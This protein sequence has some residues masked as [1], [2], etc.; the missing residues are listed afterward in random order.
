MFNRKRRFSIAIIG[1]IILG[2]GYLLLPSFPDAKNTICA[3]KKITTI[4]CPGCGMGRSTWSLLRG[5]VAQSLF[6]HPLGIVFNLFMIAAVL[7]A[8]IDVFK[9]DD[10]LIRILKKPWPTWGIILFVVVILLV[11]ARN[12]WVGL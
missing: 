8:A 9:N 11:W 12:I 7:Q 3:F 5:H 1:V 10:K 6:Y 4:P 2:Y